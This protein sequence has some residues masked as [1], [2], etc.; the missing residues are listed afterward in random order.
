MRYIGDWEDDLQS[1][2]GEEIWGDDNGRTHYQGTFF[3]GKKHGRGRFEWSDGSYY[4][5]DFVDGNF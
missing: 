2:F 3:K 4:E 5:G 1:G